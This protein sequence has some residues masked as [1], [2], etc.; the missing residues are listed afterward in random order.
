[1]NFDLSPQ[2]YEL[3]DALRAMLAARRPLRQVHDFADSGAVRDDELLN[4]LAG[5]GL[6]G[7]VVPPEFGGLGLGL[8]DAACVAEELGYALAPAP[9]AGHVLATLAI[10]RFG[11]DEQRKDYLP[12]L[13]EGRAWA[14]LGWDAGP[15]GV[16]AD[17]AADILVVTSE[18]GVQVIEAADVDGT[19]LVTTDRTRPMRELPCPV[20]LPV[21]LESAGRVLAAADAYG[22]A[23]RCLRLTVDYAKARR[24]WGRAIGSFQAVKHQ[25][26]D[27]AVMVE[28]ARG[29]HWSAAHAFDTSLP[30]ATGAAALAKLHT[31][32]RAVEVGRACVELHGGMGYTWECDVHLFL[33]RAL[34][35]RVYFGTP[36]AMRR[37]VARERGW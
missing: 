33:R 28:P 3:Q 15:L 20:G 36:A 34:F 23:L 10:A 35:D 19:S 31:A 13:A 5:M 22:A 14:G 9:Y 4:Q 16:L 1:V 29:L 18:D 32:E 25:L 8:L 11:T 21:L 27:L 24:Q 12:G 2:Q 6:A 7:I 30:D 26:A 17:A 37:V